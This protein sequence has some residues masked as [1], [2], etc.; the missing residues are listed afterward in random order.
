MKTWIALLLILSSCSTQ[1]VLN[2][3]APVYVGQPADRFFTKHG[4]P[5]RTFPLSN[6]DVLYNW[7]SGNIVYNIPAQTYATTTTTPWGYDTTATHHQ[8]SKVNVVCNAQLLVDSSG[9]IA[10]IIITDDT[11]GRWTLSRCY[12]VFSDVSAQ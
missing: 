1:S 11:I 8:A 7:S 10:N 12:E 6:G 5:Y 2:R 4:P 3:I 9:K